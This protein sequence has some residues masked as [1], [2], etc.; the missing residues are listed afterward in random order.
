MQQHGSKYFACRLA[1]PRPWGW[2]QTSTFSEYGQIVY[3][4][5]GDDTCCN[6]VANIFTRRPPPLQ[7]W[8][9][10]PATLGV[11]SNFNL[12]M[13]IK[14]NHECSNMVANVLPAAPPPFP[15][16]DPR[17]GSKCQKSTFYKHGHVAYQIKENGACSSMVAIILPAD[18]TPLN[19]NS[20]F[21]E[22]GHVSYQIKWNRECSNM[23]A[24][25][26]PHRLP[27]PLSLG[28]G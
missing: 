20:T 24:N 17:G 27:T 12:N 28:V 3:Q 4:I 15:N 14:W 9:W 8:G 23:V 21:S 16:P 13:I 25:I 5:K 6:M 19:G 26:L 7:H 18:P 2:G 10:A 22:H 11:G 1:S